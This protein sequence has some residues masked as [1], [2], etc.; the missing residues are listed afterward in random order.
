MSQIQSIAKILSKNLEW[1]KKLAIK[2]LISEKQIIFY[3]IS[4]VELQL[5]FE[6][7]CIYLPWTFEKP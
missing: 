3:N 5:G 7:R 4:Y 1:Y 6:Y 2:D